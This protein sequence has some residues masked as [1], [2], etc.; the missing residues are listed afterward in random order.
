MRALFD[1]IPHGK[2][3]NSLP[4]H[5]IFSRT[6]ED[7]WGHPKRDISAVTNLWLITAVIQGRECRLARMV[8]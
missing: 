2:V 8:R 5:T 6:L 1:L 4:N 3:L 7:V